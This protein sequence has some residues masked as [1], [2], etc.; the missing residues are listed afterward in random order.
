MDLPVTEILRFW[1][2]DSLQNPD[3]FHAASRRWF[4][5]S[6][7]FDREVLTQF[8]RLFSTPCGLEPAEIRSPQ[9]GLGA[10]L[11]LDQF[12]R[13]CFR[14]TTGAFAWDSAAQGMTEHLRAHGWQRELHPVEQVFTILPWCHAEDR[15]SQLRA[16]AALEALREEALS[17]HLRYQNF[18]QGSLLSAREHLEIIEKF[19]RFPHRNLLLGRNSTEAEQQYLASG[20][21]RFGQ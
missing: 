21:K 8:G 14:G 19:G 16:V 11:V 10:I 1:F 4:Q 12:S 13:N 2:A 9:E 15:D 18:V 17:L 20:G 7:A 6:R 5:S 3:D